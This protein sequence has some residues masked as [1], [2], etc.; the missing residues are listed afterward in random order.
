MDTTSRRK[1]FSALTVGG[2]VAALA[3][4]TASTAK[5]ANVTQSLTTALSTSVPNVGGFLGTFTLTGI[6]QAASG[7][8]NAVGT[9]AG[10]LLGPTGG[11]L[12][13]ISQTV[14]VPLQ[15]SGSCQIL[16]LTIGPIHLDLLGLVIDLNQ[17][18]LTITAVPGAGNLLGNLLCAVANLLNGGGPLS[19]LLTSLQ[20]L[21]TQILGAL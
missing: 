3:A 4:G 20:G 21:L 10:T 1:V 11:I 16:T 17:V 19:N 7:A 6:T 9:L 8:L 5:A 18:V 15:V 13:T 14:T 12:G 2:G